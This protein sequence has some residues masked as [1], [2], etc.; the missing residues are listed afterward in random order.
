[1]LEPPLFIS[2]Q[3]LPEKQLGVELFDRAYALPWTLGYHLYVSNGR[4]TGQTDFSDD[5]ALGARFYASSRHPTP[6]T[7]GISGFTGRSET[8]EK[9]FGLGSDGSILVSSRETIAFRDYAV[10]GDVSADIGALRV[11]TGGVFRWKLYEE[12]KRDALLPGQ[13]NADQMTFGGCATVAYQLPWLGLEPL[14][15]MELM[16]FALPIAE[17]AGRLTGGMNVYLNEAITLRMSYTYS[18][19]FDLEGPERE[20][21]YDY[22]HNLAARLILAF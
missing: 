17:Y 1:M 7:F 12:G 14:V 2:T 5:K 20:L 22:F 13:P 18:R 21:Q 6:L 10:S 11:R 4:T 16:R 15:Q 8:V 19:L 3:M 9:S